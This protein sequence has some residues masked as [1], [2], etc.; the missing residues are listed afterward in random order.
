M[1]HEAVAL[2]LAMSKATTLQQRKVEFQVQNKQLLNH[3]RAQKAS[4]IRIAMLVEDIGQ[5]KGL[6]HMCSFC[7]A[8]SDNNHLISRISIYAL[9]IAL[10]EELSFP[11]CQAH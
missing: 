3:I 8:N 7:L 4:D 6:F 5:L 10:D 1:V 9:G 2:K 11:Q